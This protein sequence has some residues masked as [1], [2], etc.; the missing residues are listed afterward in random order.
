MLLA[1]AVK[2]TSRTKRDFLKSI[3]EEQSL[4]AYIFPILFGFVRLNSKDNITFGL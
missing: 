4:K 1:N 3:A 2:L